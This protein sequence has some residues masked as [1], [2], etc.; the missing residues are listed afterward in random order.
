MTWFLDLKPNHSWAC[1]TKAFTDSECKLIV[2]LGTKIKSTKGLI[3]NESTQSNATKLDVQYRKSDIAFFDP[4]DESTKWIFR[5]VT[6]LVV[7]MN[8]EFWSYDL[9]YIETLQF[10]SYKDEDDFYGCHIDQ[11]MTGVHNRKLSFSV[12]LSDPK[13]YQGA[14]LVMYVEKKPSVTNKQRGDAVFFPS[15]VLHEV[16]PLKSGTRYSLVGW[17]CGPRFR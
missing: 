1:M 14:E 3:N 8:K 6:D 16:T 11:S 17:V 4:D 7:H 5:K 10:T 15:Y 13:D 12:Q 2:D 9:Q